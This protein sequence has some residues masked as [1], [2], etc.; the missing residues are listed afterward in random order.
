MNISFKP[1]NILNALQHLQDDLSSKQMSSEIIKDLGEVFIKH[2]YIKE[3]ENNKENIDTK[4]DQEVSEINSDLEVFSLNDENKT[5]ILIDE[6]K[7]NE[8]NM[9]DQMLKVNAEFNEEVEKR[10]LMKYLTTGW[11]IHTYCMTE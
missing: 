7:N 5:N 3:Y 8:N 10:K 11:Y 2:M 4:E 9:I 6:K 1:I